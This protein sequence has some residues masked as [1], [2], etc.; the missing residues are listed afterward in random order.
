MLDL[1]LLITVVW[2]WLFWFWWLLICRL[3]FLLEFVS[4][5]YFVYAFGV[6]FTAGFAAYWVVWVWCMYDLIVGGFYSYF[7][8]KY[9]YLHCF[10]WLFNLMVCLC[11]SFGRYGWLL[12]CAFLVGFT[13]VISCVFFCDFLWINCV[14]V[15]VFWFLI[16]V[17][18]IVMF[19][20]LILLLCVGFDVLTCC[21]CCSRLVVFCGCALGW[22][23]LMVD[24]L[25]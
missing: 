13:C 5:V 12:L 19:D 8:V 17:S 10:I 15:H 22:I 25:V 14:Y 24:R 20:L 3:M 21:L 4:V 9:Y 6:H 23:M 1:S 7:I 11:V 18:L 16:G 2:F